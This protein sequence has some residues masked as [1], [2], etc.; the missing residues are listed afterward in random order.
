MFLED[1]VQRNLTWARADDVVLDPFVGRGTTVFQS[2][3]QGFHAIGGDVNAVAVC[4]ARAKVNAPPIDKLMRRLRRL[5]EKYRQEPEL[6][7]DGQYGGEDLAPFFRRCYERRTFSEIL[8]LRRELKWRRRDDD[9][10]IAALA[11]GALH[12]ESHRTHLCFSNRMPRTISTKPG[13]SLRWWEANAF[14]PMRRD[15]FAILRELAIFRYASEPP[16]RL[17]VVKQ[18]D[19]RRIGET[20]EEFRGRVGLV[21]TSPPY[22][23]TT[24]YVEDQWLRLWFLGARGRHVRKPGH[25]DRHRSLATYWDFLS[26]SWQGVAPLLRERAQVVV[27]IGGKAL[28]LDQAKEGLA[29]SLRKGTG[30]R[31]RLVD[32]RI[33]DIK[34]S[35]L[36][37]FRP[38]AEG[39][40][41]EYDFRFVVS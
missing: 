35:Q 19:A 20:F 2:A 28:G 5:E 27:R 11:L 32:A 10:F 34:Q 40:K 16:P 23:D 7:D 1:F 4:V 13:Y 36:R 25:D 21:I 12:G 9:C 15:V 33:S 29:S 3:L 38:G 8:Y 18:T 22:H 37:T 30:R 31:T 26:E 6:V 14:F 39:S 17:A 41:F 24:D